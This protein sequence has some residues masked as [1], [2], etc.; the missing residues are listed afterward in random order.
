MTDVA[1]EIHHALA[2]GCRGGR[3]WGESTRFAGQRVGRDHVVA[4]G[5]T[6]RSSCAR[7]S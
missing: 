4:D 6:W 1:R 2:S 3:V 5:D 7:S